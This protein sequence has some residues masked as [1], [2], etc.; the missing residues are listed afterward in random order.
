MIHSACSLYQ[1]DGVAG[2]ESDDVR[3]GDDAFALGFQ[4]GFRSVDHVEA[5]HPGVV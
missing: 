1:K 3:A 4:P 5:A 2:C